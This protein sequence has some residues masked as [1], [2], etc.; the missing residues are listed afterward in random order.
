[1]NERALG[2]LIRSDKGPVKPPP[3]LDG[4]LGA[5]ADAVAA[6]PGVIATAHWD[7]YRPSRVDGVDFYVGEEELGHVH[8]D[9]SLHLATTPTLGAALIAEGLA[10]PFRYQ[11]GWVCETVQS[12][13]PDAAVT[14]FQRNYERLRTR[15][16]A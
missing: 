2:V 15:R 13:G 14:L 5:V 6:W 4:P 9:G 3:A 11:R 1:M 8:L 7:L 16:G 10:R 12:I